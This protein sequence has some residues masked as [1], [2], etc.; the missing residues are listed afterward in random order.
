MTY[1]RLY[2]RKNKKNLVMLLSMLE[3]MVWIVIENCNFFKIDKRPGLHIKVQ[4][5]W[6]SI[7]NVTVRNNKY[8]EKG[9]MTNSHLKLSA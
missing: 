9:K 7:S 1:G 8:N 5:Y 6:L 2:E 4:F 3:Q